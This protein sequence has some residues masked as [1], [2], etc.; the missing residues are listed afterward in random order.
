M[1]RQR[2]SSRLSLSVAFAA[3]GAAVLAIALPGRSPPPRIFSR[4]VHEMP[5]AE[6]YFLPAL[7]IDGTSLGEV[8][9]L[10][11]GW[12][13]MTP[14]RTG[15][16]SRGPVATIRL[17]AVPAEA[18]LRIE[19]EPLRREGEERPPE[20]RVSINGSL[21]AE[22]NAVRRTVQHDSVVPRSAWIDGTNEIKIAC[23][24]CASFRIRSLRLTPT[25]SDGEPDSVLG[26]LTRGSAV[27]GDSILQ[28]PGAR[29]TFCL[30]LPER[31][32]LSFA[33][34]RRTSSSLRQTVII[35]RRGSEPR[36]LFDG[37]TDEDRLVS[38]PLASAVG[39]ACLRFEVRQGDEGASPA[40]LEPALWVRPRLLVP[41]REDPAEPSPRLPRR[42]NVVLYI[43][44][45]LR[46][47]HL[48]IYGYSRPTSPH[49]SRFA[50]DAITFEHAYAH[51]VWTKPSVGSL[52]TGLLP[53]HHGA[54]DD[55]A[56]LDPEVPQIATYLHRLGY[57]TVGVQ[58]NGNVSRLYGFERDYDLFIGGREIRAD[59]GT[60]ALRKE[61]SRIAHQKLL[62]IA[63]ELEEPFFLLIQTADP[64]DPYEP[65]A[66]YRGFVAN[67]PLRGLSPQVAFDRWIEVAQEHWGSEE[68]ALLT[69]YLMGLYDGEIQQNDEWF[70]RLLGF[71]R[72]RGLYERSAIFLTADHGEAFND[73]GTEAGH[74]G[75]FCD[76]TARVPLVFKPPWEHGGSR[77]TV[78]VQHADVLPTILEMTD[79][80]P[81]GPLDGASLFEA[82]RG[83]LGPRLIRISR[84]RDRR[85]LRFHW[86]GR[87]V[88]WWPWKLVQDNVGEHRY[89]LFR[90]SDDP[91]TTDELV[92]PG[93]AREWLQY[94]VL[95]DE[96]NRFTRGAP[97]EATPDLSAEQLE[98]LRALGYVR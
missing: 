34:R 57:R 56:H 85:I 38:V 67:H 6:A 31:A 77:V 22:F 89:K 8:E 27:D 61:G 96:M 41:R 42:P 63:D 9:F 53:R 46:A 83:R 25:L 11:R 72:E 84:F 94:R 48:S 33:T 64:H 40:P 54:I 20:I 18:R 49:I 76:H 35:E 69:S 51:S 29:L 2:V 21:H 65:P 28:L 90:L 19:V 86:G 62:E 60:E 87:A 92:A 70:G 88:V 39:P 91:R 17:P 58:L 37:T 79:A 3:A 15:Q 55:V 59:V 75:S 30:A 13:P 52:L 4:L 81:R 80:L 82:E 47:D 50:R 73:H 5:V 24:P 66:R 74:G 23:R 16:L 36:V 32:S 43:I 26:R 7:T 1:G 68:H 93:L 12:V 97:L 98:E 10:Q 78:P 71:L 44:D 45:T 95:R 14:G